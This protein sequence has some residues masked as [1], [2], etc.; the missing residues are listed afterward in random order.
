MPPL[1]VFTARDTGVRTMAWSAA[2]DAAGTMYF[3]CDTV[4]TFD[5]DR[6]RPERMDPTYSI[7]GLDIGPD[8]RIW[9]AGVNEAGWLAAAAGGR[10]AYHSLVPS[11]P[12][13]TPALGDVWRVYAEGPDRAVFVTHDRVLRW[14]SG[15]FSSWEY[16]GLR[17][18]WSMRTARGIYVHYP[19]LGLL[20][21]G[22]SGP[23]LV[24]PASRVGTADIRWLDDSGD[25]WLILT[26]NGI[27]VV[28]RGARAPEPAEPSGF[29]ARNTPTCAVRL[30]DGSLAVGTLQGGIAIADRSGRIQRVLDQGAGLPANQVYGLFIARDGALWSM[31]PAHIVRLSVGSGATLYGERTGY[32]SGGCDALSE[33]AGEIFIASHSAI[34]RLEGDPTGGLGR[35][36][37]TGVTSERFYS[38]LDTPQG[39]VVGH[40]QGLGILGTDGLRRLGE[41]GDVVFRTFSSLAWPGQVLVSGPGRVLRVDPASGASTVVADSLPDYADSVADEP[42]GR[43]WIGTPSRGL[44]VAGPGGTRSEPA[45]PR[46]GPLPTAGAELVSRTSSRVVVVCASG[47]FLL[48]GPAG[49]FVPI[50]GFPEGTPSAISNPGPDGSVW[51]AMDP[52]A[53][54]HSARIGRIT[55]DGPAAAWSPRSFEGLASVGSLLGLHVVASDS[56]TVLWIC[57]SEGLLRADPGAL[58]GASA[59]PRPVVRAWLRPAA[60]GP[61][62]AVSGPVPYSN[63]GIHVEFSSLDFANRESERFETMLA[64]AE[65]DWSAPSDP[66]ER[67]ISGLREGRYNLRVRL[68][69]DSGEAGEPADLRLVVA[70]PWWRTPLAYGAFVLAVAAAVTGLVRLRLGALRR[71][72]EV[73]EATVRQRTLE[74]EKANAAKTE[75]VANMSHE[76][77][78]PMGGIMGTALELS[79]TPLSPRQRELVGTLRNCASFLASLVEDVLDFAAIEAGEYKVVRTPLSPRDVLDAAV[80][81]L[82]PGS[83]GAT[84]EALVEPAVPGWIIGDAARIGQVVVNFAA[85]ALKFG[86]DRVVLSARV[87]G[88]SIVFAVRDNGRGIPASDQRNLFIRFSRLKPAR[89]AAIPG[90]GLG[91]A[92]CRALAERMGGS[93]GVESAPG[94]GS[95]FHLRLPL[96]AAKVSGDAQHGDARGARALVVEDIEYNARALAMML[97]KIGFSVEFAGDGREALSRLAAVPYS[98][99]FL[100]CDLPGL[101]GPDVARSFRALEPRGSHTLIIATTALSTS[102]DRD[103][104]LAA[105]MDTFVSKPITPEKLRAALAAAGMPLASPPEDGPLRGADAALDLGV[106][107]QLAE[108]DPAGFERELS[109]FAASLGEAANGIAGARAGGSRAAVASAAHRVLSHARLVGAAALAAAASDLQEFAAAYSDAELAEESARVERLCTELLGALERARA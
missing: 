10:L 37:P 22:P 72:A 27:E 38:L 17:L 86:G 76:I 4:V 92:V 25:D 66:A 60:G 39:L 43:L 82:Q 75:F 21:V 32:P 13:G 64:G 46:F 85:N 56:G 18:L 7:R 34:L 58:A 47:A 87:D 99:V 29:L 81:M 57:G 67:D 79:E 63:R 26:K 74:L 5:G 24:A 68:V 59:P 71:R 101:S 107:R 69:S 109:R 105:G 78:N 100:D 80:R 84:L 35:F 91:L 49:R 2:Q 106:I 33:H 14:D 55:A 1:R 90:T 12:P 96:E 40:Y 44:F 108:G 11:L 41:P 9:V 95:T 94:K 73:L 89:N 48:D 97:R 53:G 51:V 88:S 28:R 36:R 30:P 54:G 61:D 15:R 62:Q 45:A 16:P 93:V 65:A 50:P 102:A 3:G 77:R 23:E 42:S 70:P 83:G 31:G 20:R 98:A 8:G 104:C 52:G 19:Q 6:W 103:A